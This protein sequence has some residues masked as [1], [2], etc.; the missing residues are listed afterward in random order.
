MGL[1]NEYPA[2]KQM[3][4]EKAAGISDSKLLSKSDSYFQTIY[5]RGSRESTFMIWFL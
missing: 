3:K 1:G 2:E 4:K 5:Q